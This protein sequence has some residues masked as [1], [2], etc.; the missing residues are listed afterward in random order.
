MDA[1]KYAEA[2]QYEQLTQ[3]V[4]QTILREGG[5]SNILVQHNV[6]LV[7]RS[8]V[9]HQIDVFW[10]FKQAGIEHTVLIECKNYMSSITLEKVRNIFA[11]AHDIGNARALMVTKTGYQ[12]GAVDFAN[13]YGI[14]LKLLR[15]PIEKDW[16]GRVRR[17]VLNVTARS[18]AS[19]EDKPLTCELA[20]RPL[21]EHQAAR[22]ERLQQDG[23]WNLPPG[24]ELCFLSKDG[25]IAT[26]EMRW[27]LPRHL[28][29]LTKDD[30]GPYTQRIKLDERYVMVNAGEADQELVQVIGVIATYFVE[31]VSEQ[32]ISDATD[33]VHTILK[34]Y[35]T[36]EVEY[37]KPTN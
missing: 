20:V 12:S 14:G 2:I 1:E 30:G 4:Y 13:F 26:E 33:V 6:N 28:E 8:G 17:I 9:T 3:A 21:D 15:R 37:I 31:S 22:I 36:G 25:Q 35:V 27:W 23:R 32:I 24:P 5:D 16:E 10:R 29:T 11:V 7:G 18:V 19:A 34:D